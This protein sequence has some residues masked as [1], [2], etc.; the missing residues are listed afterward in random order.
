MPDRLNRPAYIFAHHADVAGC[1]HHRILRPIELLSKA[2]LIASRADI[3]VWPDDLLT[4]LAPDVVIWQRQHEDHQLANMERYRK[5]LPNAFIIYELDDALAEVPKASFHRSLMPDDI[6]ERMVRAIQFCDVVAVSTRQLASY[7]REL[8]GPDVQIRIVPNMLG[9]DDFQTAQATRLQHRHLH[10][11]TR[12]GWGG[13]ISHTGDLAIIRE[14][15][16]EL[17]DEVDWVFLGMQPEGLKA[18][19]EFHRGVSPRDYLA[20][21][22]SLDLDLVVAPLEENLFNQCKSNLRLLEAGACGYP[23]IASP[24]VNYSDGNPPV[25]GYADPTTESWVKEI[26]K[27]LAADPNE[28][29]ASGNRLKAWAERNYCLD[30]RAEERARMWLPGAHKPFKPKRNTR[31][32][33]IMIVCPSPGPELAKLGHTVRTSLND[34]L[35]STSDILYVA[36]H[37]V[38][39]ESMIDRLK[40]HLNQNP[41]AAAVS[42]LSNDGGMCGFPRPFQFGLVDEGHGVQLDDLA[43]AVFGE[44]SVEI[45]FPNGPVALLSRQAIDSWGAPAQCEPGHEE[46]ALVEWGVYMTSRG[47]KSRAAPNV[48]VPVTAQPKPKNLQLALRRG[49]V[50]YP[51]IQMS[52]DPLADVRARFELAFHRDHYKVPLPAQDSGYE[53][54]AALFDTPGHRDLLAMRLKAE[55]FPVKPKFA[56]ATPRD[57]VRV[58]PQSWPFHQSLS[59]ATVAQAIENAEQRS[60][61]WIIFPRQD[62]IVRE[63]A[64]YMLAEKIAENPGAVLVYADH[65]H[66]SK[67]GKR[68]EHD[69][70]PAT[71]DRELALARDYLSPFCAMRISWLKELGI[72]ED[73][74]VG[75][76]MTYRL[77]LRIAGH[78]TPVTTFDTP[79]AASGGCRRV[80]GVV[81]VPRILCH[82][83]KRDHF[84][85]ASVN[86]IKTKIATAVAKEWGWPVTVKPHNRGP[87]WGHLSYGPLADEPLVSIVVPTKNKLDMLKP[88]VESLLHLTKYRNYEILIVDNGSDNPAHKDYQ[89]EVQG[90]DPR[91]R[92]LSWPQT[93]N[94]SQLNN[95]AAD[96]AKGEYLLLLNDDTRIV[97]GDWLGQ[98]VACASRP[99]VG[100]VGARLLYPWGMVQHVGVVAS[101]GLTG[102]IHKGISDG[103]PGYNGLAVLSHESTAVTGACFMMRKDLFFS[104]GKLPED[105]AHNFNDVEICLRLR[106]MGYRI[107]LAAS[108][109]L[110]HLEGVTRTPSTAGEGLDILRVEA[111]RLRELH[112]E[113]DTFW[114]P[115]LIFVHQQG[116]AMVSGLNYDLF[117]WPA[118]KWS[119]RDD[120]W[121]ME[122]VMVV[123]DD[124][125]AYRGEVQEGNSVYIATVNGFSMSVN[126]PPLENVPAWDIRTPQAALPIFERLGINR[127][128][129]RSIIGA[130]LELLSFLLQIGV[131]LDYR[132]FVGEAACPRL[133]FTS[134]GKSCG[135]G[136]RDRLCQSCV[137]MNGSP[138]GQISIRGWHDIWQR[139]LRTAQC[140]LRGLD[141]TGRAAINDLYQRAE[142][143]PAAAAL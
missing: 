114:N 87:Q 104:C 80:D 106:K 13:G 9:R 20:K 74:A 93:Y 5:T 28:R 68:C 119:W 97:D 102:H 65:D 100:A 121:R 30:D 47:L 107:V 83:K 33:G 61:D 17:S 95:W 6:N 126:L 99:D 137:D 56:I 96:F 4:A 7:M 26:R 32:M 142:A 128:V 88:C 2:G 45:P 63:H 138:F 21:L 76:A 57:Y 23:V 77:A 143:K 124:G 64:L 71:F 113:P 55:Q 25:F 79:E 118:P 19:I 3:H 52:P 103:A 116:G 73:D 90:R 12:I 58:Q 78:A 24:L 82:L 46:E 72:G 125:A 41:T 44:E 81:H 62:S 31:G 86:A 133:N 127:I 117:A 132:P 91:V 105:L 135:V 38:V 14:A 69:F 40:A 66:I 43:S 136:W 130:P 75:E 67:E 139:F 94:W 141:D 109:Q 98:M 59:A 54:W 1:G 92:L 60:C 8:C 10:K 50:R 42:P 131:A 16:D 134:G 27:F 110:H 115:N 122:R 108:A 34:A 89:V 111:L 53:D 39:T 29:A 120:T 101:N 85:E 123:G 70:K 18:Q 84:R 35:R 48:F 129:V 11:K 51:P 22:A 36:P 49:Q 112:P 37:A 15:I 140:D